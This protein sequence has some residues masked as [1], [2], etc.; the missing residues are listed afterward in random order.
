MKYFELD[1]TEKK[2]LKD[3][4][5]GKVKSI[6]NVAKEKTAYQKLVASALKKNRNINIR[7]SETDLFKLKARASEEGIPYQTY[8]ASL[9]HKHLRVR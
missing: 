1:T 4:E 9:V 8:L 3:F 7:L 6:K 2:L 5:L